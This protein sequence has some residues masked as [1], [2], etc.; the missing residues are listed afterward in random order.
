MT[1]YKINHKKILT[2]FLSIS[3]KNIL[4]KAKFTKIYRTVADIG[5]YNVM[6]QARFSIEST[7]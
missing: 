4:Q 3:N 5:K 1:S 7:D 2:D 6:T